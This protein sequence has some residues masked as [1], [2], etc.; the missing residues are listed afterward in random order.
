MRD[1]VEVDHIYKLTV[2]DE[3]YINPMLG[4]V[5]CWEKESEF[6][7]NSDEE[8]EH[9]HTRLH[10]ASKLRCLQ[11][12]KNFHCISSEVRYLPYFDGFGN[13]RDFLQ[14]FEVEISRERRL[15]ALN[16]AMHATPARWWDTH[17]EAF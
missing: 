8:M 15:W 2:R 1:K 13:I 12:I 5:I 9:W 16:L 7:S 11:V 14:T 6:F 3:Y 17:K 4:G 10:K